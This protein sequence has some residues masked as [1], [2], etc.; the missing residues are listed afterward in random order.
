MS[1][2]RPTCLPMALCAGLQAQAFVVR[3]LEQLLVDRGAGVEVV[4]AVLAER[5]SE[6]ARAAR[7]VREMEALQKE[8]VLETL[9]AIYARPTRITRGKELDDQWQVSRCGVAATESTQAR[10]WCS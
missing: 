9:V 10:N 8:G 3:R 1:T 4:R 5:G 7:T 6:P 2:T